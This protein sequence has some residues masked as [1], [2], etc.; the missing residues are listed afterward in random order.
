MGES[1]ARMEIFF[2]I[3]TSLQRFHL[4]HEEPDGPPISEECAK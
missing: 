2:F 4:E 1:I 3:V